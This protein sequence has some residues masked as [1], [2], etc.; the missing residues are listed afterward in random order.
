MRFI[1]GSICHSD[2]RFLQSISG[3]QWSHADAPLAKSRVVLRRADRDLLFQKVQAR[4]I[5]NERCAIDEAGLVGCQKTDRRRDVL[6]LADRAGYFF[7]AALD[8]G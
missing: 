2:L 4:A 7:L 1:N 8:V 5:R 6:R 3:V